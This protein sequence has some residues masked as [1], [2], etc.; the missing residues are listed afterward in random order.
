MKGRVREML[1]LVELPGFESRKPT[2]ISGGQAQ[3]ALARALINR[4]AVLLLDEPLGALDLK[5]RKQMQVELKRI[6]QEVGITFIYVT[7][8]QEEAMTMSDRIAVMN[9]GRYEQLGDPESLYER[10]RRASS[11]GSSASATCSGPVVERGGE[12]WR[13]AWRTNERARAGLLLNGEVAVDIGVRPRRSASGPPL[14]RDPDRPQRPARDG[15][16]RLVPRG[17]H[18]LQVETADGARLVVYEQNIERTVHG[19]LYSRGKKSGC[20]GRR[21]TFVVAG[22]ARAPNR[23]SWSDPGSDR[24]ERLE[25]HF[26][27][28]PGRAHTHPGMSRRTVL[29]GTAFA[30]FGSSPLRNQRPATAPS[31]APPSS[32][33]AR[34]RPASEAPAASESPSAE[35]NFANWP[36]YID[37]D[38][39]DRRSTR[40]LEDFTAKYG[41]VVNYSE[42]INDNDEFFGTIQPALQGGQDT[43]WDLIVHTDWMAAR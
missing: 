23:R 5:L 12:R 35:L 29:K 21:T 27:H 15:P 39:N 3:R 36:L 1:A 37:T 7:H 20:R 14:G 17:E 43:G 33:P 40:R 41:T 34:R 2:Q 6:Q 24:P 38:E 19:S 11:P 16:R 9:R 30:G 31:A 13:S 8:D 4:P 32:A 28:E 18:Q 22:H 26:P 42:V 10:R 25:D